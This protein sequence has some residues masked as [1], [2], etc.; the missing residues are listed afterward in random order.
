MSDALNIS[1]DLNSCDK[2]FSGFD[3]SS[4]TIPS[5]KNYY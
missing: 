2:F 5:S 1:F 4:M 3:L